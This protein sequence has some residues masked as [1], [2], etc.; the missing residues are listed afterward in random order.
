VHPVREHII[1][2]LK[3]LAIACLAL[4]LAACGPRGLR[5]NA[6]APLPLTLT[7][8]DGRTLPAVFYPAGTKPACGVVLVHDK[9]GAGSQWAAF[10]TRL[11]QSGIASLAFDMRGH[12]AGTEE[13]LPYRDF[14]PSDWLGAGF[15]IQAA[16]HA[17]I[18][19]GV[20]PDNIGIVGA[21]MGATL[22]THYAAQ[23]ET[24]QALV[25]ISPALEYDGL[26]IRRAFEA[27]I[28]RPSLLVAAKGDTYASSSA[29]ALKKTASTFCELREYDGGAHGIDA[30]D[31]L[32]GA[33][34]EVAYWLESILK[35][36]RHPV[37]RKHR[38][39]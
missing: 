25:L 3:S 35:T 22:A 15:D 19:H 26:S 7:T 20:D 39:E 6:D 8:E 24:I 2:R 1:Q 32:S 30:L 28:R 10:A 23:D 18:T 36:S 4:C 34:E 37:E 33:R 12:G 14:S 29:R 21:G 31:S 5:S 11:Q 27:Y 16:V 38:A 17:L 13:S 9:G